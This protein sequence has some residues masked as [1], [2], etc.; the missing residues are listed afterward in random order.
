M[1]RRRPHAH[2]ALLCENC[3]YDL[4]GLTRADNCPECGTPIA[5]S[6]PENRTGT[7]W[8]R[9]DSHEPWFLT[10]GLMI[11]H[12][13][14]AWRVVRNTDGRVEQFIL[15]NSFASGAAFVPAAYGTSSIVGLLSRRTAGSVAGDA[16]GV[17]LIVV[18]VLSWL[19]SAAIGALIIRVLTA[20][21]AAG[22]AHFGRRRGWR[23]DRVLAKIICAHAGVMWLFAGA[24][25]GVG[26]GLFSEMEPN[27]R[28]LPLTGFL[29]GMLLFETWVYL[30]FRAMRFANPP[31]AERHLRPRP[32]PAEGEGGRERSERPGEGDVTTPSV[33]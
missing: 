13:V 20:I 17:T 11:R 28:W 27:F 30:G 21:E 33:I 8:Q 18:F 5:A 31:G 29:L 22:I 2:D 14:S 26:Y 23:T 24:L 6:L 10:L 25:A 1:P 7:P 32:L 16:E 15:R 9:G 3:G 4:A 12:P 19:T